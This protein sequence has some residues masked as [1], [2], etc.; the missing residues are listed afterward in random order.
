MRER[1]GAKEI[2]KRGKMKRKD[3]SVARTDRLERGG[4]YS[5]EMRIITPASEYCQGED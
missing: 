3:K 1:E 2:L 5:E 4:Y